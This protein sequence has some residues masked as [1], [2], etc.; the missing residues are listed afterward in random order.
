MKEVLSPASA[1]T[2]IRASIAS[3]LVR[4][5]ADGGSRIVG[6]DDGRVG[7]IA[8]GVDMHAEKLEPAADAGPDLRQVFADPSGKDQGLD[9]AEH[10]GECSD[11]L[12]GLIAEEIDGGSRMRIAVALRA[13]GHGCCRCFPETPTQAGLM[14]DQVI[15]A[16]RVEFFCATDGRNHAGI[17]IAG[18][19]GHDE[20]ACRRESHA[21]IDASAVAHSGDACAVA[22][23]C[24][25]DSPASRAGAGHSREFFHQ[26]GAGEAVKSESLEAGRAE[27]CGKRQQPGHCR[28][29]V[30]KGRVEAGERRVSGQQAAKASISATC[31]GRCSGSSAA[32][33]SQGSEQLRRDALGH[34]PAR[35][36]HD[37][38]GD[39]VERVPAAVLARPGNCGG[40]SRSTDPV[41]GSETVAW[42]VGG[43]PAEKAPSLMLDDPALTART[44]RR[45]GSGRTII[46]RLSIFGNA[47]VGHPAYHT[48]LNHKA[49]PKGVKP[50]EQ[51]LR[52]IA[53]LPAA[54]ALQRLASRPGGLTTAEVADRQRQYGPNLVATERPARWPTHLWRAANSPFNYI[55]V[56]IAVLS[57]ITG[58]TQVVAVIAVLLAISIVLPFTQELRSG[59][60]AEAL[61][62]MVRVHATVLRNGADAAGARGIEVPI[63]QLV[64]GDIVQLA[65]GDMIP[66]DC[67]LLRAKDC[68]S[69][70]RR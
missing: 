26:P 17:E 28:H 6:A 8:F 67:R 49:E 29:G 25:D 35:T 4:D 30:V 36:D 3:S 7:T 34:R 70:R 61:R 20:A 5:D 24:Q 45:S 47:R 53:A 62:T 64:P 50:G 22:E 40:G 9:A 52:E 56:G 51:L 21:G 58:D 54:D 23:M 42:H 10:G 55:L 32:R 39:G 65:A 19:R 69:A 1:R 68:S 14:V 13:A 63:E 27:A 57:R 2:A 48:R 44:A 11:P 59:N 66:A 60:A 12:A 38:V 31:S 43:L 46:L 33:R 37:P 15:E 16:G 18:A 41:V